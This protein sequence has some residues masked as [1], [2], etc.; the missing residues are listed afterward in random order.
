[1]MN[2]STILITLSNYGRQGKV[3]SGRS[4]SPT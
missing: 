4:R 1:M 3:G 2:A